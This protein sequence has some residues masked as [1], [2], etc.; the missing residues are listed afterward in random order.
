MPLDSHVQL[1]HK[2]SRIPILSILKFLTFCPSDWL[3][4]GYMLYVTPYNN[5]TET[6]LIT[7]NTKK[8]DTSPLY[9]TTTTC[10]TY[11]LNYI[12]LFSKYKTQLSSFTLPYHVILA[13]NTILLFDEPI[14]M[15]PVI[16]KKR[17]WLDHYDIHSNTKL[18][19]NNLY[20]YHLRLWVATP[21]TVDPLH[22][23]LARKLRG[24]HCLIPPLDGDIA[25][26][27]P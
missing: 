19:A 1:T 15:Q 21:K 4:I 8:N 7:K 3:N 20:N 12:T 10:P 11:I 17:N 16:Y 24:Y 6:I 13:E 2:F 18:S 22:Y 23:L 26:R 5:P 14:Y 9:S 27:E 25:E